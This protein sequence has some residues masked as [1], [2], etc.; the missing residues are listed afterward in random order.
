MACS[1]LALVSSLTRLGRLRTLDTVPKET[2]A[3]AATF[4][5]LAV[6]TGSFD[7]MGTSYPMSH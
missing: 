4:L 1:T 6:R 2:P 7:A 3:K 5:T